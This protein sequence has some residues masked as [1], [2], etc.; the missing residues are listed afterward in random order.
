MTTNDVILVQ[1]L[2]SQRREALA[3]EMSESDFFQIFS[4]EQAL[5]DR[6]LSYDEL[7]DGIVDGGGDG[8]IDAVYLF[9]NNML[10]RE[11]IDP[12]DVKRNV[13]F[14]QVFV[15]AK[16]STGF[17]EGG[18]DRF[19]S[20][21]RDLLDLSRDLSTLGTVYKAD[22]IG[23]VREF[24]ESY[25]ALTLKFPKLSVRYYYA[26]LAT[27]VHPNVERKVEPLRNI[28]QT[29]F[30]PVDF[31]CAF[32]KAQQLLALARRAPSTAHRLKITENPISTGQEGFVCL[33]GRYCQMLWMGRGQAAFS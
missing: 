15:Q 18:M 30:S 32:L 10:Y 23:K 11:E 13:P 4:A 1:Q 31:S 26:A 19:A 3:P 14:E 17:S 7:E 8:G 28:V 9:V 6:D 22:L 25:L 29:L 12:A 27:E 21:T 20:S 5:R 2:L 33:V 24:R 16:K